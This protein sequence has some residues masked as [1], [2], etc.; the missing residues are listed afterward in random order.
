[1]LLTIFRPWMNSICW[2]LILPAMLARKNGSTKSGM[3]SW[4]TTGILY[5]PSRGARLQGLMFMLLYSD[6]FRKTGQAG[7]VLHIMSWGKP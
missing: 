7:R 4:E 5:S 1:M 3:T 6:C 2:A